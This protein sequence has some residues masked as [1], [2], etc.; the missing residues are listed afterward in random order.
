MEPLNPVDCSYLAEKA[1]QE[2][3]ELQN[4]V[5]SEI[6]ALLPVGYKLS[7]TKDCAYIVRSAEAC[8]CDFLNKIFFAYY[9]ELS[10]KSKTSLT[11]SFESSATALDIYRLC[12]VAQYLKSVGLGA[13]GVF[14]VTY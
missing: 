5:R 4:K 6:K 1:K 3:E 13:F 2:V 8:N 7:I 12:G 11:L 10:L 9:S 14:E